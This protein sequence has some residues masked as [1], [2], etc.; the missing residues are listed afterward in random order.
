MAPTTDYTA[1]RENG[2]RRPRG[3]ADWRP[4]AKTKQLLADIEDVLDRYAEHLPLT[5]R[6]VYYALVAAGRLEKTE[7][8]YA[9]LGEHL[10]RARR[11]R[12]IPF[13]VIRDDGV[14]TIRSAVFYGVDDFHEETAR[15][16]RNY[17]RDREAGQ[18]Q[19]IEVWC[20]AA[21]MLHQLARVTRDYSIPVY[22]GSGFDSLTA[23]YSLA[24]RALRRDMPT[25][26]LH[27][28]DFDPSGE[29]VFGAI[30][31]DAAAFVRED[32]TVQTIWLDAVRI[33]L[34]S[35]QVEQHDLPTTPAKSTD[36]R[37]AKW[38]GGTC[39]LEALPPDV[40]AGIVRDAIEDRLDLDRYHREVDQEREDRAELLGLPRGEGRP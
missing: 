25:V 6:Q 32:R 4:Q 13:D 12:M 29:S 11:A 27:V 7:L 33:A 38:T 1:G 17:K 35:E 18:P 3:Y 22:S 37:A 26:L 14:T 15:R 19:R 21:G 2:R 8:A 24:Q 30:A 39:Q 10:N 16:A 20:E 5:I 36:S 23:K 9:R 34:T 40:L 28:G 31:E